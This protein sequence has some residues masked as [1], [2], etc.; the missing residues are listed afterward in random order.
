[1]ARF[2]PLVSPARWKRG[3]VRWLRLRQRLMDALL[4][5]LYTTPMRVLPKGYVGVAAATVF[6]YWRDG[7]RHILM[8]RN[9]SGALEAPVGSFA[10]S[11]RH[12]RDG[13]ARLVSCFGLGAHPDLPHA[14]R[15]SVEAQMGK[16][17]FRTL[18]K[19]AFGFDRVAA[20]PMFAFNDDSNGISCPVQVLAWA[21]PLDP[22]QLDLIQLAP[23]LE[24]AAL[25]EP[26]LQQPTADVSPTHRNIW[27]AVAPTLPRLKG[28]RRA[29]GVEE[30]TMDALGGGKKV[31]V[32]TLH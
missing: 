11:A 16:V 31:G 12:G 26:A 20:A 21:V 14:M 23:G 10:R 25:A 22:I 18:D 7:V 8:V 17:F 6:W 9:G 27:L 5:A 29:D 19:K 13:R 2:L 15:A 4:S 1:M 28:S 24:L 3:W 30:V 32:K